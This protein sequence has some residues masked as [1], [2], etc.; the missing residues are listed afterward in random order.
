MGPVIRSKPGALWLLNLLMASFTSVGV[1]G[2]IGSVM[3]HAPHNKELKCPIV[4]TF[5]IPPPAS[6]NII[7]PRSGN[8]YVITD[9]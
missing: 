5:E 2:V 8:I 3:G 7:N 6:E 4:L 1:N 9:I